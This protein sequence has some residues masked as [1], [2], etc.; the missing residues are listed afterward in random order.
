MAGLVP[1]IH[2]LLAARTTWM[3]GPTPRMTLE[4]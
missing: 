4:S 2:V 3:R 1:S